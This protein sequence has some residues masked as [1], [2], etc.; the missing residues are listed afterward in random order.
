MANQIADKAIVDVK[1]YCTN[2]NIKPKDIKLIEY[3]NDTVWQNV[4]RE[5]WNAD[6]THKT[7]TRERVF[8]G[9]QTTAVLTFRFD[10]DMKTAALVFTELGEIENISYQMAYAL[11]N[12]DKDR[13]KALTQA[14]KNAR[15]KADILAAA[16]GTK[17]VAAET[18]SYGERDSYST[19]SYRCAAKQIDLMEAECAIHDL[20][21]ED[22][23]ITETVSIVF[24][25]E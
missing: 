5:V 4:D 3:K 1:E 22:L 21:V 7:T 11:K 2:R 10:F 9:Y 19:R 25:I 20:G 15:E 8:M 13:N 18:I 16:A 24:E 17:V 6:K 14:V 23:S 12:P